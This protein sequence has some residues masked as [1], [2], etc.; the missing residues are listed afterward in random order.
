MLQIVLR[1]DHQRP[2]R[3]QTSIQQRLAQASGL[4]QHLGKGDRSPGASSIAPR[5]EC[6]I[7]RL[8][9]PVHQPLGQMRWIRVERLRIVREQRAVAAL[10]DHDRCAFT[11]AG[12]VSHPFVMHENLCPRE[13]NK[14]SAQDRFEKI[15]I[16]PVRAVP[17]PRRDRLRSHASV[18]MVYRR[19]RQRCAPPCPSARSDPRPCTR[20]RRF[21]HDES[22]RS[23]TETRV[24]QLGIIKCSSTRALRFLCCLY[25]DSTV[26]RSCHLRGGHHALAFDCARSGLQLL[27][28]VLE[29]PA[30]RSA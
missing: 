27:S 3:A 20:P 18:A 15:C 9:R 17:S 11:S 10:A 4:V 23:L 16:L 28:F 21:K 1:Q 12:P 26:A 13:E 7:G 2:L 25:C 14:R 30:S 29:N 22:I 19:A 24:C 5:Q 6:P 8:L